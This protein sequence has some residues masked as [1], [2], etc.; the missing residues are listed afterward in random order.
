MQ[1]ADAGGE[2]GGQRHARTL[3]CRHLRRAAPAIGDLRPGFAQ[4]QEAQQAAGEHEGVA[5]GK[6]AHEPFLDLAEHRPAHKA[7]A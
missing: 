2:P 3:V 1:G 6:L 7:Q 4:A 5:L